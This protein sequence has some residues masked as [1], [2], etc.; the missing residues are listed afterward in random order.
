MNMDKKLFNKVTK[1]IFLEY[2]FIKKNKKFILQLQIHFEKEFSMLSVYLKTRDGKY[3][4][5]T[6]ESDMIIV[7]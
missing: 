3:C 4:D 7:G 5:F 2:G 1:K 6:L